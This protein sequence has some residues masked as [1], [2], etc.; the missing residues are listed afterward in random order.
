MQT[1]IQSCTKCMRNIKKNVPKRKSKYFDLLDVSVFDH[2]Y[3]CAPVE[4]SLKM[5]CLFDNF[6]IF[7]SKYIKLSVCFYV[8]ATWA[9]LIV[10]C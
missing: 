8:H 10:S 7:D 5:K 9:V 6:S 2:D 3:T 1:Y 4:M